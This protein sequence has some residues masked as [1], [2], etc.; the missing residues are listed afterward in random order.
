MHK[1]KLIIL[2][3]SLVLITACSN[4]YTSS[5]QPITTQTTQQTVLEK[6]FTENEQQDTCNIILKEYEVRGTS[7]V[8][9]L[10][11][12]ETVTAQLNY[13]D[14]NDIKRNN[15]ALLKFSHR[16]DPVIKIIK[17]IPGDKLELREINNGFNILVNDK[18][19]TTSDSVPY[20]FKGKRATMISLYIK[21][22]NSKIPENAYLLLGN[23]PSGTY[24]S[25]QFG[26]ISK[27]NI[28][29]KIQL[30]NN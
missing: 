28:I 3:I 12:G 27:S 24:D 16:E 4:E 1:T 19:L 25:T 26:L 6:A 23:K 20:I 29:G 14:C 15:I 30:Q 21:D 5:T 11:P 18:L 7:L 8:P 2:L 13:Y 10:S 17:G 22:Y 9:I